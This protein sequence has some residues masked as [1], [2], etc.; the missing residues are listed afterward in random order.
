MTTKQNRTKKINIKPKEMT[1]KNTPQKCYNSFS[2][3]L[4]VLIILFVVASIGW[5]IIVSKP[6]MRKSIDEIRIEVK[7]IHKKIDTQIEQDSINYQ[8]F[9]KQTAITREQY[10]SSDNKQ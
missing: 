8:K 3:I 10:L 4:S 9:L 7:N 2:C 6:A 5:D 1:D